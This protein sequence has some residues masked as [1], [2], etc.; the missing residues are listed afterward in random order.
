[1][2]LH[3]YLRLGLALTIYAALFSVALAL[4]G[5]GW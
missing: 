3:E 2:T 5:W 1:M 4:L